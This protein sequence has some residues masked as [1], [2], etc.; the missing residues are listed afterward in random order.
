MQLQVSRTFLHFPLSILFGIIWA[1]CAPEALAK[2]IP[3]ASR[4]VV[5]IV[6]DG[7]R[8]DFVNEKD[9]PTL[10]KLGKDGVIFRH[11]HSVYISATNVNGTALVT[12][13]YPGHS[14]IIANQEYRPEIDNKRIIAIENVDVIRKGDELSQNKYVAVPTIPE[15]VRDS[16]RKS[17]VATAKTIGFLQDRHRSPGKEGVVLAFGHMFS[18]DVL[19][20][21]IQALGPFPGGYAPRDAWTTKALIDFLW[22][23]GVPTFSLLWLSEPDGTQHATGPGTKEALAAVKSSDD[24]LAD[25]LAA[26]D[27]QGVRSTTD[28]FVVS[29]HGFS[30][31]ARSVDLR[32]LLKEAGFDVATEFTKEPKAGDIMLAANGGTVLFYVMQHD[33]DVTRRLVEFLQKS[34]FAG[35]IMTREKLEGTFGLKEAM[36]D[37]EHAPDV[38][39]AFRWND[40][41]NAFGVPGMIDAD[42]GRK[43]GEGTH[44]TLSRFDMHNTLVAAGPSIR[45]GY[46]S[47]LPS[48]NVDL[49]PTVLHIL[50][51]EP[52]KTMDGRI[53]VEALKTS[54]NKPP[55]PKTETLEATRTFATGV[56]RQTLQVS[57]MSSTIYLD[58]GNGAFTPNG[59]E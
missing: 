17:I 37:S 53:L 23:E 44:A 27:R 30:T 12:G 59:K 18:S 54:D 19:P 2:E 5:L 52:P 13:A 56:W 10:W 24:K 47:D 36:I 39:M 45:R 16:G 1:F 11:H 9:A 42:W 35:V 58:E 7:M 40:E 15:L 21:I 20:S 3:L 46:G 26:L 41:K 33:A 43:A 57:R 4:H 31:I 51:I 8:P 32:K 55:S 49:A 28:I 22:K 6:W 29:D 48:G 34:D 25:V 50:G 14:G 38:A